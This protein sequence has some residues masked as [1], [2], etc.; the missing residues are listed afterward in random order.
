MTHKSFPNL[1][2]CTMSAGVLAALVLIATTFASA[3]AYQPLPFPQ[4]ANT[5]LTGAP[6]SNELPSMPAAMAKH[7]TKP[8]TTSYELGSSFP[9]AANPSR[10]E[11]NSDQRAP[12][13][14]KGYELGTPFPCEANPSR[15]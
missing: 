2:S 8:E 6:D 9:A 4:A 13:A 12:A 5:A 1:L 7:A 15:K 10:G 14:R 3:Q 11:N